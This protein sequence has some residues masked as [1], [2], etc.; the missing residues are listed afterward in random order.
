MKR[1]QQKKASTSTL[2]G[3]NL[4]FRNCH[5]KKESTAWILKLKK[6]FQLSFLSECIFLFSGFNFFLIAHSCQIIK[7]KM[8]LT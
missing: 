2:Q 1:K 5:H 6:S 3:H 8:V 4:H 7:G